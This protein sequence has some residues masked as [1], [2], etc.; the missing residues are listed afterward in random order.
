MV[1]SPNC[2][3]GDLIQSMAHVTNECPKRKFDGNLYDIINATPETINW[4]SVL[5]IDP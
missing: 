4:I 2:D 3:C 5:D 1:D